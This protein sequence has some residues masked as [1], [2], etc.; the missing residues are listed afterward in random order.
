VRSGIH[1]PG[2]GECFSYPR[3]GGKRRE[4]KGG[5]VSQKRK[6]K[7]RNVELVGTLIPKGFWAGL[8]KEGPTLVRLTGRK[9]VGRDVVGQGGRREETLNFPTKRSQPVLFGP[10]R[11][12]VIKKLNSP[13]SSCYNAT[14]RSPV[15]CLPLDASDPAER[16]GLKKFSTGV[17]WSPYFLFL[18]VVDKKG[19]RCNFKGE[20][21]KG[22]ILGDE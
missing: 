2:V 5:G 15:G 3:P 22:E 8:G 16:G 20:E 7:E 10:P 21:K 19:G 9:G 6:K 11:R 4:E 18:V 13:D 12:M 14:T 17:L 1:R